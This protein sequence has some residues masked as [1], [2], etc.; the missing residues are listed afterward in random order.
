MADI[1]G[2]VGAAVLYTPETLLGSEI[3]IRHAGHPWD[4]THTAVRERL[5]NGS[6]LWA[7][8]FGALHAGRYELRVRGDA[9]RSIELDVVG[10]VV[11][12]SRW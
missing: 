3:E 4:G 7:G 11:T 6:V 9:S 2:D 10:G 5:V 8:F 1:G 12:E